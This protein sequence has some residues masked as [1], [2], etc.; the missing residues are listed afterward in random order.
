MVEIYAPWCGHC[1]DF[2]E[3]WQEIGQRLFDSSPRYFV[4]KIDGYKFNEI[5]RRYDSPGYPHL[6]F[7]KRGKAMVYEGKR[8]IRPIV[9]FVKKHGPDTVQYLDCGQLIEQKRR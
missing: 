8:E 3:K 2:A 4:A 1:K 9:D 7:F 5:F 6:I